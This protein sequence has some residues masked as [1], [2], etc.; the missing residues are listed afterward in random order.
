[1]G[2]TDALGAPAT[3]RPFVSTSFDSVNYHLH[4]DVELIPTA[5]NTGDKEDKRSVTI[6][7]ASGMSETE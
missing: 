7:A 3:G 2:F 5:L 1:V 6:S 4:C